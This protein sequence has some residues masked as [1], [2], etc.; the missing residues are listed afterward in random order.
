MSG[1]NLKWWQGYENEDI[2][3][4]DDFRRDFCTFHELL[5]ILDRYPYIVQVKYGHRHLN[6][7]YIFIITPHSPY[8]T[9]STREDIQQ[10]IR[11]IDRVIYLKNEII[12][13]F[14]STGGDVVADSGAERR[15]AEII[16]L[17]FSNPIV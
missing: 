4:I 9:Y 7:P 16:K 2:V 15:L 5:R 6:S 8:D 12:S 1:K 3:L 14:T 13:I 17:L 10:L 11:R